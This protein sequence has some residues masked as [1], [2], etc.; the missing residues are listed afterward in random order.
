MIVGFIGHAAIVPNV[1][2]PFHA[3]GLDLGDGSVFDPNK[4]FAFNGYYPKSRVVFLGICGVDPPP[5]DQFVSH[6]LGQ[7]YPQALIVPQYT[8]VN[9]TDYQ[10]VGLI[11]AAN[12][13]VS[14]LN[15]LG[16]PPTPN[17]FKGR[18]V[19]QAMSNEIQ[20]PENHGGPTYAHTW[21]ILGFSNVNFFATPAH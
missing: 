20:R 8:D 10:R 5:S 15:Q 12:D 11:D 19:G 21:Q 7:V 18:D 9:A 4:A 2:L 17:G 13:L 1:P 3:Q 6:W 16:A 14:F